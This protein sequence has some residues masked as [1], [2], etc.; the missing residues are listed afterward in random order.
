MLSF[1]CKST[2]QKWGKGAMTFQETKAW[3]KLQLQLWRKCKSQHS[4]KIQTFKGDFTQELWS[5]LHIHHL[6]ICIFIVPILYDWMLPLPFRTGN[7]GS[8]HE[9]QS[10]IDP[11][12]VLVWSRPLTLLS[13][14]SQ[15]LITP[16]TISHILAICQPQAKEHFIQWHF[17]ETE[18]YQSLC[19]GSWTPA[20]DGWK[21]LPQPNN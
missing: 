1:K 17:R 15:P 12:T 21:L 6:S 2:V 3:K 13:L 4:R 16:W 19:L 18:V 7:P 8:Q 5:L 20:R 10:P 14:H 9:W 11:S